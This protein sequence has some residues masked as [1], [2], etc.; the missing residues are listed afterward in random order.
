LS[1]DSLINNKSSQ[2]KICRAS[3][4]DQEERKKLHLVNWN[5]MCTLKKFGELGLRS[6]RPVNVVYK[7]RANWHFC[8]QLKQMWTSVIRKKY[9]CGS[10]L[11]SIVNVDKPGSNF[12]RGLCATWTN[13]QNQILW[14]LGSGRG[15]EF[16]KER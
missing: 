3:F 12:W 7:M 5:T 13:F 10:C 16:W 14:K 11:L 2:C 1:E 8:T 15:V 6:M 9:K 4:G